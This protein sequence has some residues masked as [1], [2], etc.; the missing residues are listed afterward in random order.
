MAGII[1][2]VLL[3]IAIWKPQSREITIAII[4]YMWFMYCFV[5]YV[6]DLQPF[7]YYYNQIAENG[8]SANPGY[9]TGYVYLGYYLSRIGIPFKGLRI[10]FG[11]IYVALTYVVVQHFTKNTALALAFLCFFPLFV[12]TSVFRSG[13]ASVLVLTACI[14]LENKRKWA[15]VG[16][17]ALI[18]IASTIHRTALIFLL[19]I[20]AKKEYSKKFIAII[21]GAAV[22]FGLFFYLNMDTVIKIMVAITGSERGT[23][24]FGS[25]DAQANLH[26]IIATILV[27]GLNL[28]LAWYAYRLAKREKG[29]RLSERECNE[30][31]LAYNSSLFC[32]LLLP[33]IIS[34]MLFIRIPYMV[35]PL[36]VISMVNVAFLDDKSKWIR[37]VIPI[38]ILLLVITSCAWAL[39]FDYPYLKSG[40]SS[41]LYLFNAKLG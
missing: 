12:F 21:V 30:S 14:F 25:S 2:F 18:L 16:F 24:F 27:L 15:W 34:S 40:N 23:E 31:L 39:Y 5:Y 32:T 13:I 7:E 37:G 10:I 22:A 41:Y 3:G 4:I 6:G 36:N 29:N 26:G 1:L 38:G 28:I 35:Y 9:E 19:L 17:V 8:I 20:F 11:T 33:V